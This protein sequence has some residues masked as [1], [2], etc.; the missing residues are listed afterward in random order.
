SSRLSLTCLV[1]L[2]FC[3]CLIVPFEIILTSYHTWPWYSTLTSFSFRPLFIEP[4][5]D[6]LKS[7]IVKPVVYRRKYSTADERGFTG[8]RPSWRRVGRDNDTIVSIADK[9]N[10]T[11]G[12]LSKKR[13]DYSFLG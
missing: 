12:H 3:C 9:A 10:M 4:P 8:H 5:V 7:D 1:F 11:T 2:K 6:R 13:K